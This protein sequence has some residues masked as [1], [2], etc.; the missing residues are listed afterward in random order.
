M[1]DPLWAG[2][3]LED[4]R[5]RI[6][7]ASSA[8]GL[9]QAEAVFSCLERET[10]PSLWTQDLLTP[11]LTFIEGLEQV[12][13]SHDA[14]VIVFS[15]DDVRHMR[16]VKST[17][18]RDNTIFEL[19]LLIGKLGR[20]RVFLLCPADSD[21]ALPTDLMG[22]ACLSYKV[23]SD[24]NQVAAVSTACRRI[25]VELNRPRAR[26]EKI[27][28]MWNN[29][30]ERHRDGTDLRSQI[31]SARH[32]IFVSGISLR[33]PAIYCK[34]QM[35]EA[36]SR[37]V[38]VEVL[39]PAIDSNI[40]FYDFHKPHSAEEIRLSHEAWLEFFAKLS[41]KQKS[42]FSVTATSLTLTHSI[43]LYDEHMFV[44]PF[45]IGLNSA[46]LPSFRL[47]RGCGAYNAYVK[48]ALEHLARGERICGGGGQSFLVS[49]GNGWES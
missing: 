10:E 9:P 32:G 41:A 30:Q 34:M 43:G 45:C 8:E 49:A 37:D 15:P 1:T 36:L 25:A 14:G 7:I 47:E 2:V 13:N 6:F 3:A 12:L 24:A 17:V 23:R 4:G 26:P 20:S 29:V 18:P 31:E 39:I 16:G 5:P 27:I 38:C 46:E 19:G 40:E 11:S 22:V 28:R 44:N 33:Y 21:I 42:G 35:I 48:D